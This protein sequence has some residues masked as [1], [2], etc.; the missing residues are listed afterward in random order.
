MA[1]L[2][3]H[4]R[5]AVDHKGRLSLPAK[6]RKL[7]ARGRE[8]RRFIITKGL[9]G[10]LFVYPEEEWTQIEGKLRELPR[11]EQ[12]TRHFVRQ[13]MSNAS[14]ADLDAQGRIAIPQ[15]LLE[16]AGVRDEVLIIGALDRLELWDPETF[17]KYNEKSGLTFEEAAE[18]LLI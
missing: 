1:G 10:C 12:K 16:M 17:R 8:G 11:F 18:D 15:M 13:I 6:I 7:L 14:Q 2:I 9:D 5:Y 4:F 3:G